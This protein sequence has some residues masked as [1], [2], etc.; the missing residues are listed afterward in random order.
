[1]PE[2][3]G[4]PHLL[5]KFLPHFALGEWLSLPHAGGVRGSG[6]QQLGP[7]PMHLAWAQVCRQV[8][9]RQWGCN[10][11]RQRGGWVLWESCKVGGGCQGEWSSSCPA[12][13]EGPGHHHRGVGYWGTRVLESLE[14]RGGYWADCLSTAAGGSHAVHTCVCM[15][16]YIHTH[17]Y[18]LVH[19]CPAQL[20][21]RVAW[22][23]WPCVWVFCVA[24]CIICVAICVYLS[25]V[26]V[27]LCMC[28][29]GA[30]AQPG[31]SWGHG[32]ASA[33]PRATRSGPVFPYP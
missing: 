8:W 15:C 7:M 13:Q 31:Y 27:Y 32:A 29:L 33:S 2:Q 30:Q 10:W 14:L 25:G 9:E 18:S 23:R 17:V 6:C 22:G 5:S 28:L 16:V 1:M 12:A 20:A 3:H 21:V 24:G 26:Y 11:T 4:L 19:L